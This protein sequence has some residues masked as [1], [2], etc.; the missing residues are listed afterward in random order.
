MTQDTQA[1][2][3]NDVS[4]RKH[5]AEAV[6][7]IS[8]SVRN[9][10]EFVI[11]FPEGSDVGELTTKYSNKIIEAISQDVVDD[12]T[13]LLFNSARRIPVPVHIPL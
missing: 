6:D 10:I 5:N 13:M 1:E 12:H 7:L 11:V 8:E 3:M 9:C 2:K 4:E